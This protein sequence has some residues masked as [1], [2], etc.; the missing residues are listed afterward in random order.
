MLAGHSRLFAPPELAL[1]AFDDLSAWMESQRAAFTFTGFEHALAHL[2]GIRME[3]ARRAADELAA[4]GSPQSLYRALQ[5]EAAP[6]TLVDKTPGYARS[7]PLLRRAEAWFEE[8]KY[9][10]LVRHPAAAIDSF[11]RQRLH[12]VLGEPEA[13]PY[14]YGEMVWREWN[15]NILAFLGEVPAA[16]QHRLVYERLVR[17]PETALREV[18]AFLSVPF[19]AA[20]LE[21]YAGG[22]M[23]AA[24]G[25]P[26]IARHER[27][28][29]GLAAAWEAIELPVMPAAETCALAGTLGYN[30]KMPPE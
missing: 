13:E 30:W 8:P 19:E 11:A 28:E 16:R 21:P 17:A 7:V 23:L 27:I 24:P 29:P 15:R 6:R 9:I 1:L 12:V 25:D 5:A 14:G 20:V 10:H 18:C 3:E 4:G 2:R 26:D 22:R